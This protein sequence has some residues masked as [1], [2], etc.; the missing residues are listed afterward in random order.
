[1][2]TMNDVSRHAGVSVATVSNVITGKKPVSDKMRRR[3]MDSIDALGYQVNLVARGL[4]TQRTSI[5]GL[6]LPDITK[7]FFQNVIAGIYDAATQHGYRLNILSSGYSFENE[8]SLVDLLTASQVD[9]I[10][11]DSCVPEDRTEEWLRALLSERRSSVPVVLLESTFASDAISSV[12]VDNASCS[13]SITQHLLDIGRRRILYLA[14]PL[15]LEHENA[16]LTG[17]IQCHE[18]NGIPLDPA[19]ELRCSF[20]SESGYLAIAEALRSGIPFDAV[21]ASN[22]QAAIGALKALAEGGLRVPEDVAVTGFDNLFP[23]TLVTPALTTISTPNYDMGV[24]AIEVLLG[25]IDRPEAG[26]EQ[27]RL[28]WSLEVRASTCADRRTDWNLSG[29]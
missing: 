27:R 3:V 6:I 9:G 2:A 18:R 21:Q 26:P 19:L 10:I 13:A 15:Q 28:D 17:Y 5:I 8:R 7:L 24:Q 1:M 25:Q 12:T 4:K 14:G 22:D 20:M 16:R 23:S 11:L 29:W